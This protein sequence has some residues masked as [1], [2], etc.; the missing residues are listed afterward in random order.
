MLDVWVPTVGSVG[1]L[2]RYGQRWI[3][4]E[5][6]PLHLWSGAIMEDI[7]DLCGGFLEADLQQWASPPVARI[8]TR[9]IGK[10]PEYILIKTGIHLFKVVITLEHGMNFCFLK[11]NHREVIGVHGGNGRRYVEVREEHGGREE[12]KVGERGSSLHF[13]KGRGSREER[14]ELAGERQMCCQRNGAKFSN[15]KCVDGVDRIGVQLGP[16]KNGCS[17]GWLAKPFKSKSVPNGSVNLHNRFKCFQSEQKEV[18]SHRMAYYSHG[19]QSS[20]NDTSSTTHSKEIHTNRY[21]GESN[22]FPIMGHGEVA[23][24]SDGIRGFSSPTLSGGCDKNDEVRGSFE[25]GESSRRKQGQPI[26]AEPSCDSC[27]GGFE[28]NQNIGL[29]LVVYNDGGITGI[30]REKSQNEAIEGN[31]RGEGLGDAWEL[32]SVEMSSPLAGMPHDENGLEGAEVSN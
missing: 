26:R 4:V 32:A 14:V 6:M 7:G 24:F 27:R 5:G 31:T 15:F 8:K 17:L 23:G 30:G 22:E 29:E 13:S 16:K 10:L 9:K 3:R 2:G 25:L 21:S 20:P 18:D 12:M 1:T 19:E 28:C 11:E